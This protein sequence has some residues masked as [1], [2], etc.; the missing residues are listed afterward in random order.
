MAR[1]Q[2]TETFERGGYVYRAAKVSIYKAGTTIPARVFT[3][4]TGGTAIATVPQVQ[5][6][7]NGA[8]SLYFDPDDFPTGQT[9]DIRCVPRDAD[10]NASSMETIEYTDLQL[11]SSY[12]HFSENITLK[13]CSQIYFHGP[14][15]LQLGSIYINDCGAGF[16]A[17]ADIGIWSTTGEV[18]L[19]GTSIVTQGDVV[20]SSDGADD[21]GSTMAG[22]SAL[23]LSNGT[24]KWSIWVDSSHRLAFSYSSPS[25]STV[26]YMNTG[27]TWLK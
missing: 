19:T 20:P 4:A 15:D 16:V 8:V 9:F 26:N 17:D 6:D 21:L 11:F 23:V 22:Y 2:W 12:Q 1:R 14:D 27:G 3:A 5:T 18:S 7:Y 13:N 25:W 24:N 10:P